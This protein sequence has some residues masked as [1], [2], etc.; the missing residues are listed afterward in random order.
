[1]RE[2][3][4]KI[5][6]MEVLETIFPALN[7][8]KMFQISRSLSDYKKLVEQELKY[9]RSLDGLENVQIFVFDNNSMSYVKA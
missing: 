1:M 7:K 8:T 2:K 9:D 5:E 4:S 6:G 3:L